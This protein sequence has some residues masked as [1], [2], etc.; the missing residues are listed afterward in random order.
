[1]LARIGVVKYRSADA[2]DH[3]EGGEISGMS[4]QRYLRGKSVQSGG[5]KL[6]SKLIGNGG[7]RSGMLQTILA[8]SFKID[9]VRRFSTRRGGEEMQAARTAK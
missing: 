6:I 8:H 2:K 4:A 5:A 9:S 7:Q 1:M 3:R